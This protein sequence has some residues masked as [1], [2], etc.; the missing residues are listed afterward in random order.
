MNTLY[1]IFGS[2]FGFIYN[3]LTPGF[4]KYAITILIFTLFV[5]LLMLPI[6]IKQQKSMLDMQR[7]QPKLNEIRAKY[8]NDVQKMNE[9]S[10]KLY[11]EHKVNP[12][13][14]C[15]PALVQVPIFIAL[16]G[17]ITQPLKYIFK[18]S[19]NE[20]LGVKLGINELIKPDVIIQQVTQEQIDIVEKSKQLILGHENEAIQY[21]TAKINAL[22]NITSILEALKYYEVTTIDQ[23]SHLIQKASTLS[24]DFFGLNLALLPKE[25]IISPLMLIP[26]LAGVTTYL[27]SK[28]MTNNQPQATEMDATMQS[29]Q[30]SMTV[31][32]PFMTLFITYTLPAGLGLYWIISNVF[33]IIQQYFLNKYMKKGDIASK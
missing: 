1:E 9:E 18:F 3:N 33:Q 32:M 6:A 5:K 31:M 8:K 25:H 30:K 26:I 16:Y 14:G 12:L 23:V 19:N 27:S 28:M 29:T 7:V 21:L 11:S 4:Y 24:V 2:I 22:P 17:V 20:I 10:M 13:G 15:L